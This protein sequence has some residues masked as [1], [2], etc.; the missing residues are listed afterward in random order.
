MAPAMSLRRIESDRKF[1]VSWQEL[2]SGGARKASGEI[3]RD[4]DLAVIAE[5]IGSAWPRSVSGRDC[6]R[7]VAPQYVSGD[8]D[9]YRAAEGH[10]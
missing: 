8:P 10:D 1:E 7:S 4:T 9:E 6:G 2:S 5:R 3:R